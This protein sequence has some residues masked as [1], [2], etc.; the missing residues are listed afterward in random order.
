MCGIAAI[1]RRPGAIDP[2]EID[3]LTR[4]VAH[5]GPDGLVCRVFNGQVAL[6]HSRLAIQDLS[7]AADQPMVSVCGRYVIIFNGEIYN[8]LEIRRRLQQRGIVFHTKFDTEV[9]LQA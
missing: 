5:R 1:V 6:G 9:V 4:S 2:A 7:R 8:F 3:S